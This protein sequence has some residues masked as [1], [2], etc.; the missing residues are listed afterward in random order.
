MQV[1]FSQVHA[2]C[3]MRALMTAVRSLTHCCGV[4][5]LTGCGS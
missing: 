1:F 2:T 4:L 5:R 3:Y